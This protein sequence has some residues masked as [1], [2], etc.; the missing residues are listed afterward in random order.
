MA[1]RSGVQTSVGCSASPVSPVLWMLMPQNGN[2]GLVA[3]VGMDGRS[4]YGDMDAAPSEITRMTPDGAYHM[5]GVQLMGSWLPFIYMSHCHELCL[6]FLRQQTALPLHF[7]L[8]SALCYSTIPFKKCLSR[9][10]SAQLPS[11]K[12]PPSPRPRSR[13]KSRI[14]LPMPYYCLHDCHY[15]YRTACKG[16]N[17]STA[18][19]PL[20]A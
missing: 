4:K 10:S 16:L 8:H 5:C 6:S 13:L 17:V 2:V 3:L 9:S 7:S 18:I 14:F 12:P 20:Y 11:H 15:F 19:I 1:P